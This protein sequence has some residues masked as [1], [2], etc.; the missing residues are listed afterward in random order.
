MF[1]WFLIAFISIFLFFIAEND[2]KNKKKFFI[3]Y[4]FIITLFSTLRFDVGFDYPAYWDCHAPIED[5]LYEALFSEYFYGSEY[6][7]YGKHELIPK[8]FYLLTERVGW[9]P[10]LFIIYGTIT[11]LL[12]FYSIYEN[13]S[14]PF[15]ALS[16]Y[17]AFFYLS[18]LGTIRQALSISI[19]FFSFKYIKNKQLLKY[20]IAVG[21]ASL[22]HKTALLL[23]LLYPVYHYLNLHNLFIAIT[24]LVVF[25]TIFIKV[26][27]VLGYENYIA[28]EKLLRGGGIFKFIFPFVCIL[29]TYFNQTFTKSKRKENTKLIKCVIIGIFLPFM[30][31]NQLSFRLSEYFNIFMVLLF[32]NTATVLWKRKKQFAYLFYLACF[33]FLMFYIYWSSRND[34]KSPFTPYRFVLTTN[35]EIFK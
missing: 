7:Q 33:S 15:I 35:T 28:H 21:I 9:R 31:T 16:A 6:Y 27:S 19:I 29:L 32:S 30:L 24:F 10:L 4:C 14:C 18:S 12:F 13:S 3:I 8:I 23:V 20:L 5:S 17:M 22:V 26:F 25:N 11:Y 1:A 2:S 34:I